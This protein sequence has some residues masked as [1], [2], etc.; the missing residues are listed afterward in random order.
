MCAWSSITVA[1]T[2]GTTTLSNMI[3]RGTM[4]LPVR[5]PHLHTTPLVHK[6]VGEKGV[7]AE[8]G[9][10]SKTTLG[11]HQLHDLSNTIVTKKALHATSVARRNIVR[12]TV[13]TT[14]RLDSSSERDSQNRHTWPS[15]HP[16]GSP[17][18]INLRKPVRMRNKELPSQQMRLSPVLIN[19]FSSPLQ[20]LRVQILGY[21]T[22]V[23]L[24][25][26]PPIS[27]IST[28]IKNFLNPSKSMV[29]AAK[30][31]VKELFMQS[32]RL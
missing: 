23:L 20:Y 28:L 21:W 10:D 13:F 32:L 8:V 3:L 24:T 27:L 22:V 16:Q 26:A 12:R 9:A 19:S 7:E 5:Q 6:A 11:R 15:N 2:S 17:H 25:I 31:W 29:F 4:K 1:W 30:R 18:S 14:R